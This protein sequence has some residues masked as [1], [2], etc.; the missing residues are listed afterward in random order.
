MAPQTLVVQ[1]GR[2]RAGYRIGEVL[3]GGR[4]GRCAIVHVVGERPGTGHHTF[5]AYVTVASGADWSQAGRI[6][7]DR[8]RVVSGIAHTAL[9]PIEA[10]RQVAAL[11]GPA[12]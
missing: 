6:D 1:S 3:F 4:A 5:S 10:A 7:H 12:R 9:A 8:T 2:V 11:L